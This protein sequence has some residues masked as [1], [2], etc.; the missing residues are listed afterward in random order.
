MELER[1]LVKAE[2]TDQQYVLGFI[3]VD[4]LK[5]VNDTQGHGA[6]DDLLRQVVDLVG[7]QLRDYDVVV[8]VGGDEFV[9]GLPDMALDEVRQRLDAVNATLRKT[10]AASISFGLV[11]R[12]AGEDLE[13][14][15]AR[16]DVAMYGA[17]AARHASPGGDG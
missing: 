13:A 16:A 7:G 10:K 15:I 9:C 6:G 1:E 4:G 17:R 12:E 2:R 8:R 11:E 5:G 3:D 14:L